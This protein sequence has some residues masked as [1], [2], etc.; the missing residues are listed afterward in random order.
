[1]KVPAR[2]RTLCTGVLALICAHCAVVP[3]RSPVT[4]DETRSLFAS[5]KYSGAQEKSPYE[6]FAAELYLT[7][8]EREYQA[9]RA[10]LGDRYLA[11]AHELAEQAYKNAKKFRKIELR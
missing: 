7:Q 11:R 4:I 3:G 8:A 5:A 1:M 2:W 9:G 6:Y 10:A